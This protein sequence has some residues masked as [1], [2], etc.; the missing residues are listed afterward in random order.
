M[1]GTAVDDVTVLSSALSPPLTIKV[2]ARLPALQRRRSLRLQA[3][4][5]LLL[6]QAGV[7]FPLAQRLDVL[8]CLPVELHD[9]FFHCPFHFLSSFPALRQLTLSGGRRAPPLPAWDAAGWDQLRIV[10]AHAGYGDRSHWEAWKGVRH[11]R[12]DMSGLSTA[13]ELDA[14]WANVACLKRIRR[15]TLVSHTSTPPAVSLQAHHLLPFQRLSRLIVQQPGLV[16]DT[17][18]QA[19]RQSHVSKVKQ[20][21]N[22]GEDIYHSHL[23]SRMTCSELDEVP[24]SA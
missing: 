8:G 10:D 3:L 19:M 9:A 4:D 14:A 16:S 2:V 20:S 18:V 1:Y 6:V 7:Q 22:A 5:L 12:L 21:V 17:V 13:E 15:L 11:L 23:P 24:L